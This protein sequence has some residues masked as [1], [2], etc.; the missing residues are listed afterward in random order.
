MDAQTLKSTVRVELMG[1]FRVV[2]GDV[3][4]GSDAWPG[5][6]SAELVQ[7]LALAPGRQLTRDEAIEALWPHLGAA[8]GAAN[9]RK[10]AHQARQ[11]F[12]D[13]G[14][15]VLR[16]GHVSLFP[17][18]ALASDVDE[19]EEAAAAALAAEDPDE[20]ARAASLYGGELLPGAPFE[21][22]ADAAR[23]RLRATHAE[24]L[25][26]AGDWMRAASVDPTDEPA[27]RELMRLELERGNRPAAIRAYGRLISAL[28]QELGVA[29]GAETRAVYD[30]CVAGLETIEPELVGREIELAKATSFFRSPPESGGVIVVRGP[31]GIG[32]SAVCR[33]LGRL[34]SAEG[35]RVVSAGASATSVPYGPLALAIEHLDADEPGLRGGLSERAQETLAAVKGEAAPSKPLTRHAVIGAMESLLGAA[36]G[37]APVA[38]VI[39]DAHLADEATLDVV[40]HLAGD[41]PLVAV[42]AYRPE[43]ASATLSKAVARHARAGK[44]LELDLAPLDVQ[45]AVSLIETASTPRSDEVVGR[46]IELAEGN[47]FLTL[48]LA[49][50]SV[51]GVPALVPTAKDAIVARFLDLPDA[52]TALLRKLAL[53][54]DDLRPDDVVA[55]TGLPEDQAFA[56]LEAALR[57]GILV[58]SDMRYRFRHDLLRQALVEQIPPHERLPAHRE[59]AERLAGT[60]AAPGLIAN[61]WLSGERPEEAEPWLLRAARQAFELGA[62]AD[63]I[64][65]LRPVLEHDQGHAEALTLRAEALDARGDAGAPAAYAA[66]ADAV[67][68]PEAFNLRAMQALATVKLGDPAGA[69]VVLE[70]LEPTSDQ[71]R[72]T[73]ALAYA[74]CAALGATDPS[75]GTRRAAEARRLALETGD[76]DS[77]TIASWAQA[78]A[79]HARGELR[80][81]VEAD[82]YE[83]QSLS[84]LAV[85]VFDGQLCI[86]QRLLYGARPYPDVI[87]FAD[88]LSAEAQRLGAARGHAFAVTIRGEAKLLAGQLDEAEADLIE[89][90]ALH[91]EIGAVTG[92]AFALQRRAEVALH[93]GDSAQVQALLTQALAIARESEVGFHLFDRIYGAR[94]RAGTSDPRSSLA[95]LEEAEEAVH[96]PFE[97]CPGCRITLAFPAAVAAAKAGDAERLAKWEE[98]LEFL[99]NVVMRLPAWYAAVEEVRGH[100]LELEGDVAG[101]R[102]QF[103]KAAAGFKESGQPLDEARCAALAAHA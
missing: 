59:A 16:G 87:A 54:G 18:R 99:A 95:V 91:H 42:L 19:F 79:A 1:G 34:A 53:A 96:G 24:L 81:S 62:Y 28:R 56:A 77:L 86:T 23:Q 50:T 37:G 41:R 31:A 66:A 36:G 57:N 35:W 8:A 74:G 29:P 20:C 17:D 69:L 76:A 21:D 63:A 61:H 93:R 15:V 71:G 44:A 47:P 27:H 67:G 14:A 32:K 2:L 6:R 58:V 88:R 60:G 52:E 64:T 73:T 83:T 78:A 55:L 4:I 33:E 46:I 22:W 9:L 103:E 84:K 68:G 82:L 13:Q 70:G 49:R 30:Q 89:G 98:T 102:A 94:V 26:R 48:E 10:A 39:D 100:R 72:L 97:T 12:G 3:D 38:L 85:N 90:A 51:A 25:R 80:G 11:A 45:A 92:E 75:E 43:P 101:A 40:Q 5:R 7:L 65:L